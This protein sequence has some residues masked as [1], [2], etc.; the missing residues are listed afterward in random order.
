M[1][2]STTTVF[3][4]GIFNIQRAQAQLVKQ[5]EQVS[6][7]RRVL[8]PADDPVAAARA[9]EVT[10]SRD[11]TEQY[12]RNGDSANAAIG[13]EENALTRYTALLQDIRTLAV[14]AGDGALTPTDLKSIA[15][16]LRGRY[17]ELLGVANSTDGNGLYLFSGYQGSTQP[18]TENSP[19]AVAYNGDQGQRL[20]QIGATRQ[21][22]VS[23]AGSDVFQ[24]IRTGNTVFE[25]SA[26]NTNTGTGTVSEGIVRD[27]AAWDAATNPQNFQVRFFVDSTTVPPQTTY[28]IVDTVNNVSLTTGAAPAAGPYLRPYQSG[29]T[30]SFARQA[31]PD[32]NAT[33][34]DYGIEMTVTGQPANGDTYT[35]APSANQDIFATVHNLINAVET[36][37]GGAAANTALA[38]SLNTALNNLDNAIDVSLTITA[39]VGARSKEIETAQSNADDLK[40]QYN[41]TLSG[42]TS[43]D[44][45][46]ALSELTFNQVTLEAAQQS[47]VR[48]QNL[49]LFNFL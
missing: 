45:A 16:E 31:P 36:G 48:I 10:Q 28:D 30:I 37:G 14:N 19:G 27:R 35:V 4:Q 24:R 21:V 33:A 1:R 5:Q 43:L 18:F 42:L 39:S 6:T 3:E 40:L 11:I 46:K 29:G 8:S 12:Q 13:L 47:F 22:A 38:N 25:T 44:Y 15:T 7:G 23:D 20:I 32:T 2:V 34:F 26:A 49:S 17:T 9:L 41:T